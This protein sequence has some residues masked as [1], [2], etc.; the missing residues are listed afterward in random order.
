VRILK[1]KPVDKRQIAAL[2][3]EAEEAQTHGDFPR[4]AAAY[5]KAAA[6]YLDDNAL[7]YAQY[8]HQ[9]FLVWLKAKQPDRAL[10]LARQVLKVMDDSNW[11][12]NSMDEVLDLKLM[13]YE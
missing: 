1:P 8:C 5:M 3:D 4:A 7:I 11:L 6:D 9:A 2:E 12:K 10:N 13:V